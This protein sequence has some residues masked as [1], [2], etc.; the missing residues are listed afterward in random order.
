MSVSAVL[1]DLDGTLV[2]SR[3]DLALAANLMRADHGLGPLPVAQ[4]VAF[5]GHGIRRLV[6]RTLEDAAHPPDLGDALEAMRRHYGEHL[7]DHTAAY[8]GAAEALRRVRAL[9][10]R[11]AVVTNKPEAPARRICRG[12]GLEEFIDTIVGGDSCPVLKP[13]PEPL[14]LALRRINADL[15]GSWIVGDHMTDLEGGRRAGLKRCFC[16]YGFGS[17]GSETPDCEVN[18]LSEFADLLEAGRDGR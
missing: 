1:F 2:D 18:G 5:V 12:L 9:G 11:T 14:R 13:D 16:R 15:R 17:P 7:L 6:E 3:A 4:I 10:Y 8:P